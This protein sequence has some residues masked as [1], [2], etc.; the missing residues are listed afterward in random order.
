MRPDF[1]IILGGLLPAMLWGMTA[2]FQKL[3]AAANLGPGRYLVVFGATIW[4]G[5]LVSTLLFREPGFTLG[6]TAFA[7]LAG[8]CFTLG[9]GLLSFALWKLGMPIS[10]AAP[11]LAAN[12]LV[13]V[14][15]GITYL[16]EGSEMDPIRLLIGTSLVLAGSIFVISA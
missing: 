5:G 4:L 14:L 16:G 13:P 10:R 2:V 6:G 12:V 9:T 3:S 15:V 8:I 1:A 11:L 7:G